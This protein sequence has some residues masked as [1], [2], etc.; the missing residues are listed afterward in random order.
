MTLYATWLKSKLKWNEMKFELNWVQ[1]L[2]LNW[3]ELKF[4]NLI[5]IHW[6]TFNI[7]WIQW[8]QLKSPLIRFRFNAI[9]IQLKRNR[10][11][12]GVKGF[13]KNFMAILLKNKT[14]E[15]HLHSILL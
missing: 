7:Q 6:M 9:Q 11:Q 1:I 5:Q 8:N 2:K 13:E 4:L 15:R 3:I 10:M 12:I 14:L